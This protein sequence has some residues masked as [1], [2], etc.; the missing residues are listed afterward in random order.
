MDLQ[1]PG[2]HL[3]KCLGKVTL[4][5]DII[6][7]ENK[8]IYSKKNSRIVRMTGGKPDWSWIDDNF[9]RWI[10]DFEQ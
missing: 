8:F 1:T 2:P 4:N 10:K 3:F 5:K 7:E 9:D 6:E